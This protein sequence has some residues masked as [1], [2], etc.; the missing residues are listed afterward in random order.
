MA[1][2]QASFT[3]WRKL[4]PFFWL[5]VLIWG[6]SWLLGQIH[7]T[8]HF[9]WLAWGA[10]DSAHHGPAPYLSLCLFKNTLHL[11]CPLC[12]LT[13]SFVLLAQGHPL[14]SLQYHPLGLLT[15]VL[16][17]VFMGLMLIHPPWA[18]ALVRRLTT[19][20]ALAGIGSLLLLSWVYKLSQGPTWW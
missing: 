17:I 16:S 10:T 13:R 6:Y 15:G 7:S 1:V 4:G 19:R 8:P 9:P 3:T 12:G 20:P 2:L 11:P 14:A 5:V 18:E